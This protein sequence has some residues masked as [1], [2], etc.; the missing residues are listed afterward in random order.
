M[1]AITNGVAYLEPI[2]EDAGLSAGGMGI[3][4]SASDSSRAAA[5]GVH[6]DRRAKWNTRKR[7]ARMLILCYY[8]A[9]VSWPYR[10]DLVGKAV[11]FDVV[12]L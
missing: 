7:E 9:I 3:S 5:Y 10:R 4:R 12:V 1:H 8:V 2:G 6:V 11:E